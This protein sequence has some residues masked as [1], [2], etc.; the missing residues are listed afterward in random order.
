MPLNPEETKELC[1]LRDFLVTLMAT[2]QWKSVEA[3]Q[4][5]NV[6]SRIAEMVNATEHS[7]Y[8][9]GIVRG[10]VMAAELPQDIINEAN[11]TE[12]DT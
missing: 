12:Q 9:R 7:E 11:G 10:F 2:E 5:D 3:R 4:R 8:K 1:A 6:H